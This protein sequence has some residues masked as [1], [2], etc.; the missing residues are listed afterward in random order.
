VE[1]LK[2]TT[3]T[4]WSTRRGEIVELPSG[5]VARLRTISLS[6]CL[7]GGTVPNHLSGA[8]KDLVE[9]GREAVEKLAES[10]LKKAVEVQS[11]LIEQAMLEPRIHTGDDSMGPDEIEHGDLTD[12]DRSFVCSFAIRGVAMLEPFR[13]ERG[14]AEPGHNGEEIRETAE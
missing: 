4:Q 2:V 10:D 13:E 6:M 12:E 8:I 5:N 1:E 11:W 3:P 7:F 9:E 14:G